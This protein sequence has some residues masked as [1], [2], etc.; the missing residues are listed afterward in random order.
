MTARGS[1]LIFLSIFKAH[2]ALGMHM[3]LVDVPTIPP[4][5]K[6]VRVGLAFVSERFEAKRGRS[7]RHNGLSS[8]L[9]RKGL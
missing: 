4:P 9:P 2:N 8:F 7:H 6:K 3:Q 1:I 5:L